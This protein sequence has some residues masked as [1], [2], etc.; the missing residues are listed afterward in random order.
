V[1]PIVRGITGMTVPGC[2]A[3]RFKLGERSC[4]VST[5]DRS[6]DFGN[7]GNGRAHGSPFYSCSLLLFSIVLLGALTLYY[8]VL[9]TYITGPLCA[10]G[11]LVVALPALRRPAGL[12]EAGKPSKQVGLS[13]FWD[14]DDKKHIHDPAVPV[15]DKSP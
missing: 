6:Y 12:F 15:N 8:L 11:G 10:L 14:A 5:N 3:A 2:Y 1:S 13:V 4:L 7:H 9:R